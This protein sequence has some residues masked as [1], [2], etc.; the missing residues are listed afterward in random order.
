MAGE[1]CPVDEVG[2]PVASLALG[3]EDLDD[4]SQ[5]CS[6]G[7]GGAGSQRA[8]FG[9]DGDEPREGIGDAL[10][11]LESAGEHPF[12]VS[13]PGAGESGHAPCGEGGV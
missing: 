7:T 5:V 11:L 13:G 3:F 2:R 1:E 10:A 12:G 6:D 4:R 8:S 9:S